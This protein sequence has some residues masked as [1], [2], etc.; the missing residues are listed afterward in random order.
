M[1]IRDILLI[2]IIIYLIISHCK[3]K[4][5][6]KFVV[7]DDI[8]ATLKEIYNTD[9]QA[10][11]DLATM[12]QTLVG[13]GITGIGIVPIGSII[14]WTGNRVTLPSNYKL[15][16]GTT[17]NG[18]PTPDLRNKFIIGANY[19][20]DGNQITSE[21]FNLKMNNNW[22]L[23]TNI[24]DG[25]LTTTGGSKNATLVSHNHGGNTNTDGAHSH[26]VPSSFTY[27]WTPN[28]TPAYWLQSGQMDGAIQKN[29]TLSATSTGS[30]HYHA[31]S[32]EGSSASN[33]NLPPYYALAFVMRIS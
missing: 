33:A 9:M 6:E 14:M 30:S 28:L 3:K 7:S 21:S 19:H 20:Q 16:D 1:N 13:N 5:T 11:R 23:K 22:E 31:I 8:K 27:I 32:T 26:S 18:I 29:G 25:Q 4:N 17:Y 15:C 10:V 24:E 12:S 2:I